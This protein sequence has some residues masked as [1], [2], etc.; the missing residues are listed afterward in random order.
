VR[1]HIAAEGGWDVG[2][3]SGL[4]VAALLVWRGVPVAETV[5]VSLVGTAIAVTLLRRY[6][7]GH[8]ALTVDVSRTEAEEPA[9]V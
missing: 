2:V 4:L 7:L 3:S 1:F 8:P 9:R 5:L 6:Y